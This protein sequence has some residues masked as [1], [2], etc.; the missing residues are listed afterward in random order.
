MA[1]YEMLLDD[2][3]IRGDDDDATEFRQAVDKAKKDLEN[4]VRKSR[5]FS[6]KL[7][8]QKAA[9]DLL[10]V[11][12]CKEHTSRTL[13]ELAVLISEEIA[14]TFMANVRLIMRHG[15]ENCEAVASYIIPDET[16]CP[17]SRIE[18]SHDLAVA[19]E[20]LDR[21]RAAMLALA[22]A[23]E[24]QATEDVRVYLM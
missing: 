16:L 18:T 23:P 19:Q 15:C 1:Y 7:S 17:R 11:V 2:A 21:I 12:C 20:N 4:Y 8:K 10:K 9:F 6:Y 13:Q 3:V 5:S 14:A 24:T 22:D